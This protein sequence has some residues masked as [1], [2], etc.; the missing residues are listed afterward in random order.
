MRVLYTDTQMHR[1]TDN[2]GGNNPM[3]AY[4]IHPE[5]RTITEIDFVG[6]YRK[7]QQTIGCHSFTTGVDSSSMSCCWRMITC[8]RLFWY[9]SVV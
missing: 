3:R 1:C 8:S 4:L 7:I 6:D 2:T 5:F 9:T